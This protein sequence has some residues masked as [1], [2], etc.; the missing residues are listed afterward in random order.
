MIQSGGTLILPEYGTP[1]VYP[2]R[3]FRDQG[4]KAMTVK[5]PAVRRV[6]PEWAQT[7]PVNRWINAIE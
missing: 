3:L 1:R 7:K 2:V 6:I 5:A 4:V